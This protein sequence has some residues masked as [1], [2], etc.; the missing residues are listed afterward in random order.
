VL[1]FCVRHP[2]TPFFLG[3][4]VLLFAA[5]MAAPLLAP[6]PPKETQTLIR[7]QGPSADHLLGTDQ[8]GRD[9]FSRLLF[10]GRLSLSFGLA[11]VAIAATVGVTLGVT[12]GYV[13]GIFDLLFGRVV[14]AVLAFPAVLLLIA[15]R[16]ALGGGVWPL[17]IV[18]GL[19]NFPGY[20]RLSR[21]QVLQ[22]REN[23]Y[24]HAAR[25][26]GASNA[27]VMF[28]HILPNSLNPLIIQS[29]FAAGGAV[30]TLST[31]SFLGLGLTGGS[32]DWGGMFNDALNNFRTQPWLVF[33]PGIAVFASV[34]SFY[35]LGDDMRDALDPR[36]RG[37]RR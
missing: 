32:P 29:S 15:M 6:Y 35:V 17:L 16:S 37:R 4:M 31:L 25:A 14:D 9:T 2:R 7:L 34:L 12:A 33:G 3:V 21:G 26:L 11:V 24:V 27:R 10:G 23:D 36:D 18:V 5:C 19:I 22:V 8:L 1:R 30:L 20:Y 28:R 13:T